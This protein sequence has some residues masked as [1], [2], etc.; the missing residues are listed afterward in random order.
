MVKSTTSRSR[1][2][3]RPALE[4]QVNLTHSMQVQKDLKR[5]VM[6][7]V[8]DLEL[9]IFPLPTFPCLSS[10]LCA[11]TIT[12]ATSDCDSSRV[13]WTQVT[14]AEMFVATATAQ[15]G[16]SYVC[17]SNSSL[18]CTFTD[19]NCGEIYSVT[20]TTMD[21]GCLSEPST[22]VDLKAGKECLQWILW[23][24]KSIC[25]VQ[26]GFILV[27]FCLCLLSQVCVLHPT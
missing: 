2:T 22:A 17:S 25:E 16:H 11:P 1:R 3:L 4:N 6:H 27:H 10:G 24:H 20:V 21:R 5:N 8:R 9:T 14:G 18:S 12:E 15:D 23:V 19:L 26:S 13:A 7:M